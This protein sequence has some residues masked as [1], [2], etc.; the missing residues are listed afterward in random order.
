MRARSRAEPSDAD[1]RNPGGTAGGSALGVVAIGRRLADS[2]SRHPLRVG[3]DGSHLAAMAETFGHFE[4]LNVFLHARRADGQP[5]AQPL[6]MADGPIDHRQ[7]PWQNTLTA[8]DL[9][10]HPGPL[11]GEPH[12][13]Q[14]AHLQRIA[15]VGAATVQS[16]SNQSTGAVVSAPAMV[17]K[18]RQSSMST[19]D[20][21]HRTLP[22]ACIAWTPAEWLL[23]A[24]SN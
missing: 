22:S 5:A 7:S 21:I 17:A 13:A 4:R 3:L 11:A 23:R 19:L 16:T 9:R 18:A 24:V 12:Q 2:P 20:A 14:D 6:D 8:G 15:K 10:R 1:R